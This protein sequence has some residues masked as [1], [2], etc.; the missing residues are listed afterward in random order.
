MVRGWASLNTPGI[1]T[2]RVDRAAEGVGSDEHPGAGEILP[3]H[4]VRV[5]AA[6]VC[7][8][9]ILRPGVGAEVTAIALAFA[10]NPILLAAA[11][12]MFTSHGGLLSTL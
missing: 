8:V 6:A 1:R 10:L 4:A 5:S 9:L 7:F 11:A 12:T 3:I 2:G